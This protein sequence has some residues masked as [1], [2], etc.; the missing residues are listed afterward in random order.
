MDLVNGK[1]TITTSG[2][3]QNPPKYCKM[4]AVYWT[5]LSWNKLN[6]P[7]VK[8]CDRV[9]NAESPLWGSLDCWAGG[10]PWS[11][12][13]KGSWSGTAGKLIHSST[14]WPRWSLHPTHTTKRHIRE[15]HSDCQWTTFSKTRASEEPVQNVLPLETKAVFLS[16]TNM[17]LLQQVSC[18]IWINSRNSHHDHFACVDLKF[19]LWT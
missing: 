19:L 9:S 5:S 16:H 3:K 10:W 11:Q 8:R 1:I 13:V 14:H 18:Y 4:T 7:A 2:G 17:L 15:T 6:R 12:T